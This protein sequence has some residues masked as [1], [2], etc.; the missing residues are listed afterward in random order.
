[1]GRPRQVDFGLGLGF[2][3]GVCFGVGDFAITSS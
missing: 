3:F 2:G 1:M